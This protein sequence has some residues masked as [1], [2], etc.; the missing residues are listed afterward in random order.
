MLVSVIV[1]ARN[2]E[3]TIG[4]TLA[5]LDAQ[6]FAEEF[7][8]VVVDDAS[9]DRTAAIA[10]RHGGVRLVRHQRPLGPG[11]A[12]NTGVATAEGDVLAFTDA[13]CF[14]TAGWVG[15]AVGAIAHADLVQGAVRPDPAAEPMPFDRTIWVEREVGLYETA[16]LIVRRDWFERVGGF[17]DW[18]GARIGKPLG[19]DLWL[20]W[21]LRR[22]GA[23]I[24]FSEEALVHHEVFRRE[25][26]DYVAERARLMYFPDIVEKVPELRDEFLHAGLFLNR[27][28][29]AFDLAVVAIAVAALAR[30]PLP[31]AGVV[32]YVRTWARGARRW[33]RSRAP[34]V[35]VAE[36]AADTAGMVAL[37]AGSVRRRTPVL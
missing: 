37:V 8:M 5:A 23:R 20:G 27:R 31:L 22:A 35:A 12:R 24:A 21:R 7:E 32:P 29:A 14:P 9:T 36:L 2:A 16:N 28:S 11:P 34:A 6:D 25:P 18:L 4:R 15:A 19:E 3:S 13:D 1:P 10:E 26:R 33:G 17:E 30:S